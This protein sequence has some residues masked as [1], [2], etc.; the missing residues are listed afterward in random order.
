MAFSTPNF[1]TRLFRPFTT[2]R[3]SL[4]PEGGPI[5]S[6]TI[7][8]GHQLAT[9]AA[10]C[11]WGVEHE[12]RKHFGTQLHDVRVGYI[13]GNTDSP[14][15]RA[16]CSGTTGHAEAAQITFD[17]EKV[18]YRTLIEF[19]YKMHDPTTKDRQGNDS[20]TQYRSGIFWHDA[21]QEKIAREVTEAV[22]RE[23]WGPGQVKTELLEAGK[24]W[25]AEDYHQE[26]L[27][28]NPYGYVCASHHI[29]KFPDL[30]YGK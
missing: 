9:V 7:P 8:A 27:I 11:F 30:K 2:T 17:P 5:A 16:V 12:Y 24:W 23:W 29:R 20:G 1:I 10:G 28:K 18:S 6:R 25:D 3:L 14:S 13:G 26:Y 15:Y 22:D 19:F 21:E 4:G